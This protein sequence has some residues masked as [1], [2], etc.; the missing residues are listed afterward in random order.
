[1][2]ELL[3]ISSLVIVIT[4][5]YASYL[6]LK[7]RRVPF[8]T[9]YPALGIAGTIIIIFYFLTL[10][11]EIGADPLLFCLFPFLLSAFLLCADWIY[12][13]YIK[14]ADKS[15][16]DFT[17]IIETYLSWILLAIPASVVIFSYFTGYF[18]II[19][20]LALLSLIFC[21]FLELISVMHLWGGADSAAMKIISS[22]VPFFPIIPLWGYPEMTFFFPMSVMLNAVI[23]N[24]FVPVGLFIYNIVKKNRAPLKYMFI[25]YPVQGEKIMDHFGFIIEDFEVEGDRIN[26]KFIKFSSSIRRMVS[27]K[28]RMYTQDFKNNPGEYQKEL[29]IYQKAGFVWISFGVPF[30]IPILA[31][32]L[33]SFFIGDIFSL[34]LKITGVIV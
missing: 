29:E 25:G 19:S 23:L 32:F 26:R 2:T 18:N 14:K 24:L 17:I 7:Q 20:I 3:I 33:F 4:L 13:I 1:M 15:E 10:G 16:I 30:I 34:L 31:G 27:G 22:T 6:D 12:T 21:I 11:T 8:K 28:R 9:W 5:L